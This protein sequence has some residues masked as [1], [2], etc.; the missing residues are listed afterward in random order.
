MLKKTITYEDYLGTIRT[1]YLYF[2]LSKTELSDMQMSVDGGYKNMLDKMIKA[3]DNKEVY[4]TFVEIVLAA[5]GEL[6]PDGKYHLKKDAEGH[7]LA[8]IWR[9]SPSYDALMDDICESEAKI[10]EFCKGIIPKNLNEKIKP[11][12]HQPPQ[13]K[14]FRRPE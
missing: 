12:D 14:Q 9:Q 5:Y 11:Q 7:R 1:E 8:D 2:N 6:S 10:A 13:V 4:K 3:K